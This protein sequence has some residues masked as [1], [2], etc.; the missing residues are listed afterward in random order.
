MA[1]VNNALVTWNDLALMGLT[2]KGTPPTG[3]AIANKAEIIAAYYV[4]EAASPFST[5]TADR[6][7]PYQTIISAATTT[8][9]TTCNPT[10]NWV[11]QFYNC[12]DCTTRTVERDLNPCSATYLGYRVNLDYVGSTAPSNT[13]ACNTSEQWV[14]LFG[15]YDCYGTCN[16]Y[17]VETQNNPCA[18]GYGN[19]R[20][21]GLTPG[22]TNS[23]FCGG[24]CG[25]STAADWT[26]IFGSYVCSGCDKYYEEVD[27]NPCSAT[28]N[29]VRRSS[30]VAE[31]NSTFC[32]GCCGQSTSADWTL[33][34]GTYWCSGCDKYFVEVDLNSCSPT[35]NTYRYGPLAEA[36]SSY[37][38]TGTLTCFS[39]D[40][41]IFYYDGC[42]GTS[43]QTAV[44]T[45]TLRDQFGNPINATTDLTFT[46]SYEY[47]NY[48]DYYYC[49]SFGTAY[50]DAVVYAGTSSTTITFYTRINNYCCY[51]S[52]CDGTCYSTEYFENII[53]SP[54]PVC[55]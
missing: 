27:Q 9:T 16:K 13:G 15:S 8:T 46:W 39:L 10:P 51:G 7:P 26:I 20:Q 11:F 52:Y 37:C 42:N 31:Y 30:L 18:P 43:N 25:Q 5:Y 45:I 19:T 21:G 54:I 34:F 41:N 4:D 38:C 29:E 40:Y 35:Y 17:Y 24:C 53:S 23:T 14:L 28:Y 36:N 32:G 2:A 47:A 55:P 48:E 6:C 49:E 44:Y 3:L 50:R 12:F 1:R 33:L 22:G